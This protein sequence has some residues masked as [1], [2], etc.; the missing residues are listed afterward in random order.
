MGVIYTLVNDTRKEFIGVGP[1]PFNAKDP[2]E[3]P[4]CNFI[5]YL[6]KT[7]WKYD[8]VLL[9]NDSG[10]FD[11]LWNREESYKDVGIELWNEFVERMKGKYPDLLMSTFDRATWGLK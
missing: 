2:E 11:V 10:D 7:H 4:Y 1:L 5:V 6:L 9:L 8:N 3:Y